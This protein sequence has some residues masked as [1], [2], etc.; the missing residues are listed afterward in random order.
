MQAEEG[1]TTVH[2]AKVIEKDIK[3]IEDLAAFLIEYALSRNVDEWVKDYNQ[4][5]ER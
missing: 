4:S 3:N 2:R 1:Y 5:R